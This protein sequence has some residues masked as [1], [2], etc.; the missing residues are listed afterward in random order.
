MDTLN[1][2]VA[3]GHAPIPA[4]AVININNIQALSGLSPDQYL[5]Q[6]AAAIGQPA[7]YFQWGQFGVLNN[8]IIPPSPTPTA[9]DSTFE[10]PHTLSFSIGVQREVTKDLV[11]QFDYFHRE[12]RNL[13]GPRLSNLAFRSRV[14]GIGRSFDPPGSPEL[15]TFGPFFEG[16][17]DAVVATFNKRLSNRYLLGGSYTFSK[18]TDNSLGVNSISDRPIHRNRAGRDGTMSGKQPRLYASNQCKRT[19]HQQERKPRTAG[20]NISQRPR[21]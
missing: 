4:N 16:K 21:S 20:R 9:V 8:P 13:L 19:V 6:A 2:V 1:N 3:P 5:I 15:P 17:Y 10:T 7:G 12:M 14:A 11:V 18:A